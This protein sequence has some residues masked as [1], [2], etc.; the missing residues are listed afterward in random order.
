M[1]LLRFAL[2]TV[3]SFGILAP[4]G[5]QQDPRATCAPAPHEND[6]VAPVQTVSYVVD[7]KMP[8]IVVARAVVEM[9]DVPRDEVRGLITKEIT[10]GV[11]ILLFTFGAVWRPVNGDEEVIQVFSDA[12][13]RE[14]LKGAFDAIDQNLKNNIGNSNEEYDST[15]MRPVQ[16]N[17]DRLTLNLSEEE[18]A[19]IGLTGPE[20]R[21]LADKQD[22]YLRIGQLDSQHMLLTEEHN[23]RRITIAVV[24]GRVVRAGRG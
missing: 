9:P 8:D 22:V 16:L 20:A 21:E 10:Y 17:N 6:G 15:R 2:L 12:D 23:S 7:L 13:T 24:G 5:A 19:F 3:L 14:R 18:K 1:S 11:K 4:V